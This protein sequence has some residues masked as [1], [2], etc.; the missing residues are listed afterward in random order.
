MG[1]GGRN[2]IPII[3]PYICDPPARAPP[4]TSHRYKWN[5]NVEK[6]ERGEREIPDAGSLITNRGQVLGNDSKEEEKE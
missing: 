6:L 5:T 3:I 2:P 4:F 1:G